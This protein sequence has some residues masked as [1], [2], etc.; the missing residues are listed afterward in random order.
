MNGRRRLYWDE[1]N[2]HHIAR[3]GVRE[4]D[5]EYLLARPTFVR[6]GRKGYW[7]HYGQD[8]G[9]RYLLVV[10]DNVGPALYYVVTARPMTEAERRNYLTR[11]LTRR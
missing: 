10:L 6:R 8:A 1:S 4:S 7:L 5:V 9:G 11:R 2:R 3:H